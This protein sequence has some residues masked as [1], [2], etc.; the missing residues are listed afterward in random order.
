MSGPFCTLAIIMNGDNMP[1]R[2][3]FEFLHHFCLT[4]L[5]LKPALL[6][7]QTPSCHHAEAASAHWACPQDGRVDK[8]KL[9]GQLRRVFQSE[10]IFIERL[11]AIKIVLFNPRRNS[12]NLF[13]LPKIVVFTIASLL[14]VHSI[15]CRCVLEA[16]FSDIASKSDYVFT[17][18]STLSRQSVV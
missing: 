9:V 13:I 18:F 15:I 14:V 4:Y 2:N 16:F 12:N 6:L 11:T 7:L 17:S 10:I 5:L 3:A 1:N 8:C